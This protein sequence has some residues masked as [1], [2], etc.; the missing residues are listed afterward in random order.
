MVERPNQVWS[1]EITH[2]PMRAGFMLL[3][4]ILDW[5]SRYVLGSALSNTLDTVF[6]RE[7]VSQ[8]WSAG[9]PEIF[10]TDQGCQLT[11]TPFTGMLETHGVWISMDGR[12]RVLYKILVE[13]LWRT[14]KYED[15]YLRDH[16]SVEESTPAWRAIPPTTTKER[17][18]QSLGGYP[19]A[20]GG[21]WGGQTLTT[22][23]LIFAT[24]WS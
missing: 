21:A 3:M 17:P 10:N 19:H 20:S 15:I 6:Y 13:R 2:L 1:T 18:H 24:S 14:V 16:G 7:A 23:L 5:Y 12:G 22:R 8:A 9:R 4:P 11:S